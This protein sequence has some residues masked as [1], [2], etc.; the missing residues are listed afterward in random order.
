[1]KLSICNFNVKNEALYSKWESNAE[2][3]TKIVASE[4]WMPRLLTDTNKVIQILNT[5]N[6]DIEIEYEEKRA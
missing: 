2:S 5:R 4:E 1:M 6:L 3:I